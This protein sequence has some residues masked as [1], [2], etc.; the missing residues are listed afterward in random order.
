MI[1]KL[2]TLQRIMTTG[3]VAVVRAKDPEQAEKISGACIKG[4][5]DAIEI[6]FTVPDAGEVIKALKRR[7]SREDLLVGAGTVLDAE[8][9]RIAILAG[10]EFIV[11]PSFNLDSAKLCNRY[12]VPYIPGCMTVTE[13]ITAM[14]AGADVIKLFPGGAFGPKI[15]KDVKGPLPQAALMPTGGVSLENVGEWIK[16]GAVA[17]GVGSQLTAG[18]KQ[19]DYDKVTR[20]AKE[21]VDAIKAARNNG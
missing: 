3:I 6:T 20:T 9:G 19:G 17:V 16:A 12:Q 5:I 13:I 10:A 14:E 21:F 2:E 1:P 8:T 11:S 4:G 15:I 7:F 18:A